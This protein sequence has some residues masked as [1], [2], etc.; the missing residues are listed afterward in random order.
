MIEIFQTKSKAKQ[1]N[2]DASLFI[3]SIDKRTFFK[4]VTASAVINI[5]TRRNFTMNQQFRTFVCR[6]LVG[7]SVGQFSVV[8][9]LKDGRGVILP[10]SYR[11]TCYFFMMPTLN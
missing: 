11:T 7:R 6:L 2:K 9:S 1:T 3:R 4:E 8:I 10:C 5:F